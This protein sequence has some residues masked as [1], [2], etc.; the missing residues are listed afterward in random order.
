MPGNLTPSGNTSIG[1]GILLGSTVL[2]AAVAPSRALIV[3]TDGIQ[4][5]D[6]DIPAATAAVAVKSPKQRVFA[7]GRAMLCR[8]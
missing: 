6:P 8:D 1:A 4:N 3:L 7:I 5:T 2:D